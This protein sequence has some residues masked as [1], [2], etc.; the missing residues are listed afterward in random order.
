MYLESR[1]LKIRAGLEIR[2]MYPVELIEERPCVLVAEDHAPL[3][4][5]IETVLGGAGYRV[6]TA[7]NGDEAIGIASRCKRVCCISFSWKTIQVM[8]SC[9]VR[10]YEVVAWRRMWWSLTT[11]K[12]RSRL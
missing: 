5:L 2:D 4:E 10:R 9:C 7:V 8:F 1:D 6:I 11:A 3:R 12:R